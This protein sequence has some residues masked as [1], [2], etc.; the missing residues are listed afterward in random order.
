MTA[1]SKWEEEKRTIDGLN[2]KIEKDF[3]EIEIKKW[4]NDVLEWEKRKA[5]FLRQQNEFN[6]KIDKMREAYLKKNP[7]SILEYCEMVL[8]NS[9]YPETFPKNFELEYNPD[10]KILIVEYELPSIESLPK[11]REVKYIAARKELKQTYI[12]EPHQNKMFDESI[13]KITLRSLHELFEADTV[14]AVAAI[15]F[16]GWARAK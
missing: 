5:V 6:S 11:V 12:S 14:D 3:N 4:E 13:Y 8:N 2:K 10:N 1:V 9:E 15:S 7:D 16:N